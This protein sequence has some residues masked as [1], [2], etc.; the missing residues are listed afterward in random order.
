MRA[1]LTLFRLGDL[2]EFLGLQSRSNIQSGSEP[3][4]LTELLGDG[5]VGARGSAA[6]HGRWELLDHFRT[7][8]AIRHRLERSA[9]HT[10]SKALAP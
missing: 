3:V 9:R 4:N 7:P 5:A 6:R 10:L 8:G 2:R 1:E